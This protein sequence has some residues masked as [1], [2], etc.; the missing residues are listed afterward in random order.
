MSL[1]T[2]SLVVSLTMLTLACAERAALMPLP[3]DTLVEVKAAQ[4][5]T[6]YHWVTGYYRWEGSQKE[7]VWVRGGWEKV[8]PN[9]RWL[10]GRYRT[11]VFADVRVQ[12]W[13]PGRWVERRR[14]AAPQV[15]GSSRNQDSD[16]SRR[17][18]TDTE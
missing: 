3:T 12:E 11:I 7:Y 6:D 13:I 17:S 9:H 4:P 10:K 15:Q 5:A 14:S 2:R 16:Q 1:L 18:S 8:I